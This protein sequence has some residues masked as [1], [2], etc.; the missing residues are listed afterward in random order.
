MDHILV[1]AHLKRN[2]PHMS[3]SP[4]QRQRDA[5]SPIVQNNPPIGSV[6][7]T[8]DGKSSPVPEDKTPVRNGNGVVNGNG[9][10]QSL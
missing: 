1:G 8:P 10:Y 9:T 6:I 2:I 3:L 4:L 5:M 7:S